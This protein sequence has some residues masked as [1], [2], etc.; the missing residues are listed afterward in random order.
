MIGVFDS[1][2]GGLTAINEIRKLNPKADICF[3]ADKENAPYGTKTRTELLGLVKADIEKLAKAT[4]PFYIVMGLLLIIIAFCPAVV[5]TVPR[6]L[7]Y[8]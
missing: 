8:M 1:G 4:I 5:L 2:I 3:F 6:M 7:G